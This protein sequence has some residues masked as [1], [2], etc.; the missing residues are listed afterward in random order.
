MFYLLEILQ[1]SRKTIKQR[2]TRDQDIQFPNVILI[3]CEKPKRI[4]F[5]DRLRQIRSNH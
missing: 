3:R 5:R 4:F 2:E 1:N